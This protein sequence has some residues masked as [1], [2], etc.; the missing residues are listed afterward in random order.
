MK[1]LL[2]IIILSVNVVFA[3]EFVVE[4]IS[5]SVKF[6][7]GTGEQWIDIKAGDRLSGSES[8][9]DRRKRFC[10]VKPERKQIYSK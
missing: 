5:G 4:K 7:K 1:K 8:A 3:Q 2:I 10:S 9:D 6:L